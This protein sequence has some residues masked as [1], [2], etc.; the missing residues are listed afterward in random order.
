MKPMHFTGI[1]N[2]DRR[3][4]EELQAMGAF[5]QPEKAH[6]SVIAEVLESIG[7]FMTWMRWRGEYG[8]YGCRV[9]ATAAYT[10]EMRSI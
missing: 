10:L 5:D 9:G 8:A 6:A 2:D 7:Q 3:I 1:A 4:A